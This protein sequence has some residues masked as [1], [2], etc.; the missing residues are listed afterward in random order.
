[1]GKLILDCDLMRFR[2]TG[3][4]HYCLNLGHYINKLF[5]KQG[6]S[7]MQFY[8]PPK[9]VNSFSDSRN[10]IV[11]KRFHKYFRPF[12][13]DCKVWHSPFQSGRIVPY[14]NKAIKVLLT[15]HDL[16]ALHEDV[17]AE[18][19]KKGLLHTQKLINRANGIVCISE[20]CKADVLANCDVG[21]KPIYVIHN[22]THTVQEASLSATSY[23]PRL[24]FLFAMGDVNR[25]KNFHTLT[26]LAQSPNIEVV[27]AGRLAESN[28]VAAIKKEA[29][30]KGIG[31]RVHILGPVTEG[32]KSWYLQNCVAFVHPSLA[33]G[34]GATVVEA[35]A[36]GKPL[37]LSNLTSLPEIGGDVAFYFKNFEPD[38]MRQIL[39]N[40]LHQFQQNGLEQKIRERSTTFNWE[41]KAEEYMAVYQTLLQ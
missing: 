35:M 37:F 32:E 12:L 31:D 2:N 25:K 27:V 11:E 18:E 17:P 8:I 33:E 28:Y 9:E 16:N 19:K 41:R 24:P 14:H 15:I 34:F 13:W 6:D 7:P 4:Y 39:F 1:M 20:F 5:S 26:S 22:G 30:E 23:K 36:F 3:L 38:H 21:V 10:C 40:G 29:E